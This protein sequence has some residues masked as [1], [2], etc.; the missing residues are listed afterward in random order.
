MGSPIC[1]SREQV[2]ELFEVAVGNGS[3][4]SEDR[5]VI[6]SDY[7]LYLWLGQK[8][9]VAARNVLSKA[10]ADNEN[11]TLNRINLLQLSRL[12]GDKVG[13]L[14]LLADLQGRRLSRQDRALV[15]DVIYELAAHGVVTNGL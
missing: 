15:Q 1:L 10:I 9:Y 12:Q 8:D 5:S 13:A 11:D 6:R 3:A 4:S 2:D 14:T 7:V